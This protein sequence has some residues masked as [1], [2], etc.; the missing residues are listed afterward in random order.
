MV[1]PEQDRLERLP[2]SKL[3]SGVLVCLLLASC[4]FSPQIANDAVDY[5]LSIEKIGNELL[6]TNIA[7]AYRGF[8]MYF[9]D[10]KKITG[11]LTFNGKVGTKIP[12]GG[13]ATND[14]SLNPQIAYE[15]SPTF[16][17]LSLNDF[18]FTRG[19]LT[20][21]SEET[22]AYYWSYGWPDQLLL[23]LFVE[24]FEAFT[25]QDSCLDDSFWE[26][27]DDD[28]DKIDTLLSSLVNEDGDAGLGCRVTLNNDP[29]RP[30]EYDRFKAFVDRIDF[31]I[32]VDPLEGNIGAPLSLAELS[33]IQSIVASPV[34]ELKVF[35]D[36]GIGK[37][38]LR[39]GDR[40]VDISFRKKEGKNGTNYRAYTAKLNSNNEALHLYLR[41]PQGILLY[42]G[43]ILRAYHDYRPGHPNHRDITINGGEPLFR[44][45]K[46]DHLGTNGDIAVT[47][48]NERFYIPHCP[49]SERHC[50]E[51]VGKTLTA[52]TLVNQLIGLQRKATDLPLTQTV[53]I[54]GN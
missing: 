25:R 20:P 54:I 35:Y 24:K 28:E 40:N 6:L 14:F 53:K 44:V 17:V 19:I 21:I 23:H 13:D 11:N 43:E 1:E 51:R 32:R 29:N 36:Q 22:F 26:D 37:Y 4:N 2:L 39:R 18:D 5:N 38:I 16:D 42:L 33:K 30:I 41:S 31:D 15:S 49:S 46:T 50:S 9:V 47:Y 34:Q 48:R 8:P 45:E 52:L 12:I 3:C 27:G 7:R 10:L